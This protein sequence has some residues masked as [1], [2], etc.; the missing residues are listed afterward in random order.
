MQKQTDWQFK[1]FQALQSLAKSCRF[2][3]DE[4]TLSLYDLPLAHLGYENLYKAACKI[5]CDRESRDPFPSISEIRRSVNPELDHRKKA[6]AINMA[7]N[8]AVLRKGYTWPTLSKSCRSVNPDTGLPYDSFQDEFIAVLGDAAW[9]AVQR[10]G[11]WQSVIDGYNENAETFRAQMRE[12][13]ES[14]L[15]QDEL[16][17]LSTKLM[18][19]NPLPKQVGLQSAATIIKGMLGEKDAAQP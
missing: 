4:H 14:V 2:D 6:V 8:N 16:G 11:G 18:L 1:Y 10:A 3:L 9:V 13:V 19:K 12:H 5:I 17:V 7:I 15:K